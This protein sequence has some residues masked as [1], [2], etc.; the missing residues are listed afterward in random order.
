MD[1]QVYAILNG[2]IKSGGGSGV[3]AYSKLETD[4]LLSNKVD[5]AENMGLSTN[6]YTTEEKNK[7]KGIATGATKTTVDTALSSTS[8][9]PVQNKVVNTALSKKVDKVTGKGL[10]TNDYTTADKN[11]LESLK[12]YDDTAVKTDISNLKADTGWVSIAN[13]NT[14]TYTSWSC[15]YRKLY[16][17]VCIRGSF[18]I[19]ETWTSTQSTMIIPNSTLPSECYPTGTELG[20]CWYGEGSSTGESWLKGRQNVTLTCTTQG[21][22]GMTAPTG[23]TLPNNRFYCFKMSYLI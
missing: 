12:N 14:E 16:K 4:N 22:V 23:S 20:I 8:T 15:Q 21:G 6:D 10:S 19:S 17:Q 18:K 9:N 13:P 1:K 2:R 7:L 5:K 3:D 11:K